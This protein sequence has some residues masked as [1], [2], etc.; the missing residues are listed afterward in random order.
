M[1]NI[2]QH[3]IIKPSSNKTASEIASEIFQETF[4]ESAYD[5]SG[6]FSHL[7]ARLPQS[8]FIRLY[9]AQTTA[10]IFIQGYWLQLCIQNNKKRVINRETQ[11]ELLLEVN[12]NPYGYTELSFYRF[13][14]RVCRFKLKHISAFDLLNTEKGF[15][16]I[17]R[18][19]VKAFAKIQTSLTM[20]SFSQAN[21]PV[22]I[23]L[24]NQEKRVEPEFSSERV[25]LQ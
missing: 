7:L 16:C 25:L 3:L 17:A 6:K 12:V 10:S 5:K 8:D 11:I 1:S 2:F 21:L 23:V 15:H 24:M 9:S 22:V 19:A 13:N 20:Q 18:A 4:V 14:K